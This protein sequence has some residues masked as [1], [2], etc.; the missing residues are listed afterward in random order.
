MD[1]AGLL[2][3]DAQCEEPSVVPLQSGNYPLTTTPTGDTGFQL[4]NPCQS[5]WRAVGFRSDPG[6]E[7]AFEVTWTHDDVQYM[8]GIMRRDSD[9]LVTQTLSTQGGFYNKSNCVHAYVST[10]TM[11]RMYYNNTYV[12]ANSCSGGNPLPSLQPG[13]KYS[14]RY[15]KADGRPKIEFGSASGGS[16]KELV[17]P[18]FQ[19]PAGDHLPVVHLQWGKSLSVDVK[20]CDDEKTAPHKPIFHPVARFL[21][22]NDLEICESS[23]LKALEIMQKYHVD[24]TKDLKVVRMWNASDCRLPFSGVPIC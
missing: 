14:M 18:G 16:W 13:E 1:V 11:G 21:I 2:G 24:N 3:G 19:I 7:D 10:N 15:S 4:H 20:F 5:N 12:A 22:A 9:T 23:S 17:I 8:V 6:D